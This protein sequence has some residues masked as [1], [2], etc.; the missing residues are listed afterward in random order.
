ME[1]FDNDHI[2]ELVLGSEHQLSGVYRGIA[3][4]HN[5]IESGTNVEFKESQDKTDVS[6]KLFEIASAAAD[7]Q[8]LQKKLNNLTKEVSE[9]IK[10][11]KIVESD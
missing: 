2:E 5:L 10:N 11:A 6:E 1:N 7:I 9:K 8:I 4:K 3:E